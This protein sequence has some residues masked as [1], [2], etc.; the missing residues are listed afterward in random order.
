[1]LIKKKNRRKLILLLIACL[2]LQATSVMANETSAEADAPLIVEPNAEVPVES[3]TE[4]PP[5]TSSVGTPEEF[6]A[7]AFDTEDDTEAL[8]Q[9][10]DTYDTVKLTDGGVYYI[11]DTL[12]IKKNQKIY[13]P[14][15]RASIIQTVPLAALSNVPKL[16]TT[17]K[18]NK[19]LKKGQS[20]I[21]IAAPDSMISDLFESDT[22]DSNTSELDIATNDFIL[23]RS[24][25]LWKEDNRGYL[26]K[27]EIHLAQSYTDGLLTLSEDLFDTYYASETVTMN[28]YEPMTVELDNIEFKN[29]THVFNTLISI[30]YTQNSVFK[31]LNIANAKEAGIILQYNYKATIENSTFHL[32]ITKDDSQTGYGIQDNGGIYTSISECTFRGVRRGVDLSGNVPNWYSTVENCEAYGPMNTTQLATGNSGFGTHSTCMYATFRNN[33]VKGFRQGFA[34]RG[35]NLLLENNTVYGN[36][37]YFLQATH[38]TNITVQKNTYTRFSKKTKLP[39]FA[40]LTQSFS[41]KIKLINNQS[42]PVTK[43]TSKAK[44]TSTSGNKTVK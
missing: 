1:M 24:D 26:R 20:A 34:L 23:M 31:N 15:V 9:A 7:N 41:G 42:S 5:S 25:Q 2:F 27:G 43:W 18:L 3:N 33:Y 8:Q 30:W 19:W 10:L 40:N 12:Y 6:G 44:N 14:E 16:K 37:D 4:P 11:S 22:V 39:V 13:T 21:Q 38:G 36:Q 28:I 35:S 17:L 29:S 32:G